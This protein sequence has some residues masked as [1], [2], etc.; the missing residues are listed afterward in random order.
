MRPEDLGAFGC[1]VASLHSQGSAECDGAHLGQMCGGLSCWY[2]ATSRCVMHNLL[3]VSTECGI[4]ASWW[5]MCDGRWCRGRLHWSSQWAVSVPDLW[6]HRGGL[7]SSFFRFQ[8]SARCG[9][10]SG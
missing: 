9:S 6:R 8:T 4:M 2:E 3:S 1:G 7:S 10:S 5:M